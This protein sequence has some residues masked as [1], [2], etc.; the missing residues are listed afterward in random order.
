MNRTGR[1]KVFS[2]RGLRKWGGGLFVK[3][4][5]HGKIIHSGEIEPETQI[6]RSPYITGQEKRYMAA[7]ME[8][9]EKAERVLEK[10]WKKA[11]KLLIEMSAISLRLT[12]DIEKR[13]IYET[14]GWEREKEKVVESQVKCET[15]KME[16]LEELS[17]IFN[18]ICNEINESNDQ[19]AATAELLLANISWYAHGLLLKP[20]S[21]H[22]LPAITYEDY[23]SQI[24]KRHEITWNA[25]KLLLKKETSYENFE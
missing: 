3:G 8:R 1:R 18:T 24:L 17:E 10:E 12:S 19:A 6:V 7:C 16:V 25:I 14:K 23:A 9:R 15:R 4:F 13:K 5:V 22:N 21:A 20:V 2:M 11:D